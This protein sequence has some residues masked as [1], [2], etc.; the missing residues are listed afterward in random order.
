MLG[1]VPEAER[2]RVWQALNR[3]LYCAGGGGPAL[4]AGGVGTR[5]MFEALH[6]LGREDVALA[7]ALK[8]T[9]PSF[10]WMVQQG[11]SQG[12]DLVSSLVSSCL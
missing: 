9:M 3:S 11:P 8:Q 12:H 1:V 2:S 7:I 5:Y 6:V 10:G 4:T